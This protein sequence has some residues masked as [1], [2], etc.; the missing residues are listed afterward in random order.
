MTSDHSE[1]IRA[2]EMALEF[3]HIEVIG[4][5]LTE[6][7]PKIVPGNCRF[8]KADVIAFLEE[9]AGV[10]DLIQCRSVAKHV[11]D[12]TALTCLI[13]RSLR[14]GGVLLFADAIT[15]IYNVDKQPYPL[16]L[17]NDSASN[18]KIRSWFARWLFEATA[19]WT[20]KAQQNTE[21]DKLHIL[22]REDSQFEYLGQKTYY[23]P[24]NWDGG[25]QEGILNG[26]EI[27]KLMLL[28][29]LDFLQASRPSLLSEGLTEATLQVWDKNVRDEVTAPTK[30]MFLKWVVAWAV[31][32]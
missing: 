14:P 25:D 15:D 22:M 29:V 3:P 18:D 8:I 24:I 19:R 6:S 23:S 32:V 1:Q 4:I 20:T 21:G 11:P 27:G 28:N 31:K 9:Y 5:D 2:V 13:G 26:A 10:F 16:A 30:R 17:V 7:N 12:A